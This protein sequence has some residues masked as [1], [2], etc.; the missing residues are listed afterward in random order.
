MS[1]GPTQLTGGLGARV[2]WLFIAGL[3]ALLGYMS[4][5]AIRLSS[6]WRQVK[7]TRKVGKRGRWPQRN[8]QPGPS[9][10]AETTVSRDAAL[11]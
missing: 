2:F 8:S 5:L 7:P 10:V 1:H 3:V 4:V 11:E 9:A 6:R